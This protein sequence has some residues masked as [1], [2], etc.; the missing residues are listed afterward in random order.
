MLPFRSLKQS[1]QGD[2][3]F[4]SLVLKFSQKEFAWPYTE[5]QLR[6]NAIHACKQKYCFDKYVILGMANFINE[7]LKTAYIHPTSKKK[8]SSKETYEN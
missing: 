5:I 6:T 1:H 8:K 3:F 2:T 7:Y 4:Q